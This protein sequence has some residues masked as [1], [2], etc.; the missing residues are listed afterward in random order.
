MTATPAR[1]GFITNEYRLATAGPDATVAARYGLA[2]RD[3][4]DPIDTFFVNQAD[5]LAMATERLT[6]LK[7]DR[8]RF[9]ADAAGIQALPDD[10]P[11]YPNTPTAQVIDEVLDADRA[12]AV[13][14][15]GID[16]DKDTTTLVCWG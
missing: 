4:P 16:F 7:A 9:S 11:P 3:T 13:A 6:L 15:I 2:A 5:A 14:E 12:A 1:I 10:L 8:R